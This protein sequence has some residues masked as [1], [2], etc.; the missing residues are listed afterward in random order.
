MIIYLK[1]DISYKEIKDLETNLNQKKITLMPIDEDNKC[2]CLLG[3]LNNITTDYLLD[4]KCIVNVKKIPDKI[5][6]VSK[7]FKV[8]DSII[9]LKDVKIGGKERIV[10]IGGPCS[11]ESKEQVL[12]IA[13]H[14]KEFDGNALRGGIFK[15]RTSPYSF[16][17]LGLKG[18][19]YLYAAKSITDLPIITEVT[20]IEQID[21]VI[22]YV[23]AIQVGA[24][25]MQNFELLKALGKTNK[26]IILKRGF[27]STIKEWLMSAE[28]I[29][30]EGNPNIILC[31]R[32]IRTFDDY[33]RFTLDLSSIPLIKKLSHLPIIVDPSHAVGR[34]DLVEPMA[35]SAIAAGADGVMIEVHDNPEKAFSDGGQSLKYENFKNLV[36]KCRLIAK[37]LGRKE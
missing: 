26:P 35:L 15:P 20:S 23:D 30:N 33:T 9:S 18:L 31:E 10:I 2:F 28:Y 16:Q 13:K 19:E 34:W 6:K 4:F 5:S 17:G 25:N 27:S 21:D 22:A 24:R 36:K 11:V 14:V 37:T 8:S 12:D 3:N 7:D 29:I 32:G 1:K